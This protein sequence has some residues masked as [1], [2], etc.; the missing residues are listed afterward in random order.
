M[1]YQD[2]EKAFS[3]IRLNRYLLACGNNPIKALALYRYNVQLSQKF[4]AILNV[5][6]VTLRNAINMHYKEYFSDPDWIK[7]QL[8]ADGLLGSHPQI[9]TISETMAIL[10]ATNRYSN[11]RMV[12]S[13]TLGFWTYLFT[14]VP[15]Q[16]GGKTLLTIFPHKTHSL[17]QR[18]IYNELQTIKAFRNRI[19]HHEAICFNSEGRKDIGPAKEYYALIQKYIGFLGFSDTHLFYGMGTR[20]EKLFM[21]IDQL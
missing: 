17:G 3:P 16:R 21:K 11:D 20:L 14:K 13:V 7:T 4:Y 6:E 15:F 12:S 5:F 2:Y 1:K 19:A 18:T 9:K 8:S 10:I